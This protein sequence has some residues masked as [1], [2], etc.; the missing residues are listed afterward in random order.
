MIGELIAAIV[1]GIIGAVIGT[2]IVLAL[3]RMFRWPRDAGPR[4]AAG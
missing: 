3:L 2:M 4:P 1:L